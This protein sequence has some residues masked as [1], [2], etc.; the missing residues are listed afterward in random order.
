MKES[1]SLL[2]SIRNVLKNFV[3][4][5]CL[6]KERNSA[7]HNDHLNNCN[8]DNF[9][10]LNEE[11]QD[12][13][14]KL[15]NLQKKLDVKKNEY[16]VLQDE[17]KILKKENLK[18]LTITENSSNPKLDINSD[19]TDVTQLYRDFCNLSDSIKYSLSN[20][21][22]TNSVL[23]FIFTGAQEENIETLWDFTKDEALKGNDISVLIR[24]FQYFLSA[25]NKNYQT[26]LYELNNDIIGS[27][28]DDFTHIRG[29]DSLSQGKI[30]EIVLP[31]YYNTRTDE[32]IRKT[33]VI[34]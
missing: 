4:K 2:D 29:Y 3:C 21:I 12:L 31:G 17:F 32:I 20:T 8:S 15:I 19:F 16:I 10:K 34:L 25:F 23:D 28:Y 7:E 6:Y 9:F 27:D 13:M 26:P 24:I 18:L 30:K 14:K 11:N 5:K 33:I 1:N 22:S